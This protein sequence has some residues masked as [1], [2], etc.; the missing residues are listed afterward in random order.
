MYKTKIES[1]HTVA[2][3]DRSVYSL[4][5]RSALQSQDGN[6]SSTLPSPA[7]SLSLPPLGKAWGRGV[8]GMTE[9]APRMGGRTSMAE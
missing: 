3:I 4:G 1:K 8:S 7:L 6:H 5:V 9:S 2:L